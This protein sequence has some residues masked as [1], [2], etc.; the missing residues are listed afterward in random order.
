MSTGQ[1]RSALEGHDGAVRS[2]AF[3]PDGRTIASGSDDKTIKLWDISTGQLRS[4][5]EGH[6]GAVCS[7]AFS[8]NGHKLASGS[9]DKTIKF[10]DT[11]NRNLLATIQGHDSGV[12]CVA[13][14]PD[15]KI[16]ASASYDTTIKLWSTDAAEVLSAQSGIMK[17]LKFGDE[18]LENG[19]ID[20]ALSIFISAKDIS[21]KLNAQDPYNEQWTH[22]LAISHQKIGDVLLKKEFLG[23]ALNAFMASK[24]IRENLLVRDSSNTDLLHAV[25]ASYDR[26]GE[27]FKSKKEMNNA[28]TAFKSFRGIIENLTLQYPSH[29]DWLAQLAIAQE[30]VGDVLLEMTRLEEAKMAFAAEEKIAE[31]LTLQN[32][33][34]TE[35]NRILG[36]ALWRK[37]H[38]TFTRGQKRDAAKEMGRAADIFARLAETLS[39]TEA[40]YESALAWAKLSW[41]LIF[42][43][44]PEGAIEAARKGL[45]V[46]PSLSWT[47]IYAAHGLLFSGQYAEAEEIYRTCIDAVLDDGNRADQLVLDHF[48]ELRQNGIAHPDMERIEKL[49]ASGQ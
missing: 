43:N 20:S 13:F 42:V 36:S 16:L 6:D 38:L 27:V 29:A 22:E 49:L 17:D 32:P 11:K 1:L 8:P 23:D 41:Y 2:V 14:S 45:E 39:T 40:R 4:T 9:G 48:K 46:E 28:L 25:A 21:E 37:A 33:E 34:N 19:G 3:S 18:I 24:E 44:Q 5:L 35:W 30:K 47:Y 15:G 10:W 31:R 12:N 26:I 7:V